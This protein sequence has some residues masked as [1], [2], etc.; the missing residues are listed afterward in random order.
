MKVCELKQRQLIKS[1]RDG[2]VYQVSKRWSGVYLLDPITKKIKI[3][4][5]NDRPQTVIEYEPAG[6]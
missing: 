5:F 6:A 3:K 2:V 1:K 4:L